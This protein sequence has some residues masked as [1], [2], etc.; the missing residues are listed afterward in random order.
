MCL[1]KCNNILFAP[2]FFLTMALYSWLLTYLLIL[3]R[4]FKNRLHAVTSRHHRTPHRHG[5]VT[6]SRHKLDRPHKC[7]CSHAGVGK[8]QALKCKW[9]HAKVV[10]ARCTALHLVNLRFFH[11]GTTLH[12][13]AWCYMLPPDSDAKC[14]VLILL[15]LIMITLQMDKLRVLP[16]ILPIVAHTSWL[17]F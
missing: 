14:T 1:Q 10:I 2:W 17:N 13:K 12:C 9:A 5:V 6:A 16:P 3:K 4:T 8:L 7:E 11:T 15:G